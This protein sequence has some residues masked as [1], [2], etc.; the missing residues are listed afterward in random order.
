MSNDCEDYDYV[1][2]H[3]ADI[4][5]DI[6]LLDIEFMLDHEQTTHR[7]T[8]ARLADCR[9]ELAEAMADIKKL[10]GFAQAVLHRWPHGGVID[11]SDSEEN[12]LDYGL[13]VETNPTEPCGPVCA[14]RECYGLDEFKSGGVV[15]YRKTELLT[16]GKDGK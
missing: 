10:R 16:G 12:A 1:D 3:H 8:K 13:L 15:C 6:T 7:E 4:E 5:A 11:P 9:A 2:Y 14:C